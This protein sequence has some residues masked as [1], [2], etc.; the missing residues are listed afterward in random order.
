[1]S[2]PLKLDH[3]LRA[4]P[5][6]RALAELREALYGISRARRAAAWAEPGE[7]TTLDER[8]ADLEALEARLAEIAER[9]RE[10]A[11]RVNRAALDS[12]RALRQGDEAAAARELVRAG[13]VLEGGGEL[14][15]AERFYRQ[16]V[17]LGRR[18]RDRT[19]EGLAHCR[20]A[21]V[22]RTLGDSAGALAEYLAGWRI[23]EA[24]GDRET[25]ALACVGRGNVHVDRGEW[26]PAREWYERGLEV[27][28]GEGA[29]RAKW[30]VYSN[31]AIVARRAGS[32]A[33][34]EGWLL[35][36]QAA[37]EATGDPGAALYLAHG[38]AQLHLARGETAEAESAFRAALAGADGAA[39]AV[40]LANLGEALLLG[41]RTDDAEEVARAAEEAALAAR[42]IGV[43]PEVYRLLGRVAAARGWRDG[44]IHF[45]QALSLAGEGDGAAAERAA[46]QHH[47]ARFESALGETDAAAARLTE[48]LALYERLGA[49]RETAQVRADLE[50]ITGT[51]AASARPS[52]EG[53]G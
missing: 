38:R 14:E 53:E 44:F 29:S 16:A 45:E 26:E 25:M 28:G 19:A 2:R 13:E 4:L 24:S 7:Y 32:L 23:A 6:S 52:T 11:E 42:E 22:R 50:E 46:T 37:A 33:A 47:Y 40:I 48:A 30:E 34:S 27:L 8:E 12:L 39:R 41:G 36:V 3:A 20:V 43:L 9:A 21:R 17:A 31:L 35:R 1:M 5:E 51:T 18:P 10:R 49:R 15:E